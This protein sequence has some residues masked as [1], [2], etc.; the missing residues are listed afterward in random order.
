MAFSSDLLDKVN[1]GEFKFEKL[2]LDTKIKP[3]KC[4]NQDLADFLLNDA[5][6]YLKY[7]RYT[8]FVIENKDITVAYYSLANDVLKLDPNIDI[9]LDDKIKFSI[10]DKDYIFQEYMFSQS[11]FP[12]V[13]IGRL[14]VHED[15]RNNGY[16]TDI[17]KLLVG[18]F[19]NN[20]KTGCQF[21][22]VDAINTN[23]TLKFYEKN[24]FEYVTVCDVNKESRQMYKILI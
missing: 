6:I 2:T 15:L 22:T 18:S 24:G 8:T 1:S 14:A 4:N 7:L 12:A 3:F 17:I 10:E 11:V 5:K 20:N 21:I 23:E 13:K 9:D 19:K 16:G